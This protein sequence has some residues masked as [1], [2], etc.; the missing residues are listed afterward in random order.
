MRP[1]W[2]LMNSKIATYIGFLVLVVGG[3]LTIGLLNRPDDWY[4]SL[5]KPDF[6]PPDWIFGP[7]WTVLYIVI[8]IVG[9]RLYLHHG[10]SAAMRLWWAALVLNFA[11]SPLFFGL[12]E[13][14]LS[15]IVIAGLVVS[16]LLFI[17]FSWRR[18]RV[19]ALL[20]VPYLAWTAFASVLNAAIVSLN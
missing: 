15:M 11:W 14:V 12:R 4:R 19:S 7:V 2:S 1:S 17:A 8:A 20:F 18:D 13:P 3:G 5:S 6:N 9:A 16:I 10:A